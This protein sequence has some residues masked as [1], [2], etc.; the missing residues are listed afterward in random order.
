MMKAIALTEPDGSDPLPICHNNRDWLVSRY[1]HEAAIALKFFSDEGPVGEGDKETDRKAIDHIR[2]CPKC[3]K[4][5]HSIIPEDIL[6]RQKR[7]TRYC[8]AGMF[9][10]FEEADGKTNNQITFEMFRGED[11]CWKIDGIRTFASYC[12]WC[13]KK[14]PDKP[15]IE[16]E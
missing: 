12:P 1:K 2:K 16:G 8:C 6:R 11:P 4:W 5:F 13:G 9:V 7:L 10:A 15:F 14:L 3:R